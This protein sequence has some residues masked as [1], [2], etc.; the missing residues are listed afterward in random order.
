[1][2]RLYPVARAYLRHTDRHH[3]HQSV[4]LRLDDGTRA[5]LYHLEADV[6]VVIVELLLVVPQGIAATRRHAGDVAQFAQGAADGRVIAVL[7]QVV[8]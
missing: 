7:E 8:R 2:Q 4:V 1:M 3:G 6:V 5:R